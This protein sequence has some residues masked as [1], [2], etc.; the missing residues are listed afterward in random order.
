V[1]GLRKW[2][3]PLF[4]NKT[5]PGYTPPHPF[6]LP[7]TGTP[8]GAPP[9]AEPTRLEPRAA[10]PDSGRNPVA[11]ASTSSSSSSPASRAEVL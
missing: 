2:C 7:R 10:H 3:F 11:A 4:E 5:P 6:K 1:P 8:T 9:A